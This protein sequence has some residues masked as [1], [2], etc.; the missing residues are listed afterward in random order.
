MRQQTFKFRTWGGKREGAG[1]EP[2]G[3]KPGVS[4]LKRPQFPARNPVHL[5]MRLLPGVGY[6][7]GYS[8]K[9]AIENAS[10]GVVVAPVASNSAITSPTPGLIAKPSPLKP[11]A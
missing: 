2:D 4:H 11:K 1:R 5:T 9:R 10:I 8:R 3:D 6:L 7:R